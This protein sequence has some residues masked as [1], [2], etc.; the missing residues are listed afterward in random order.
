MSDMLLTPQTPLLL[1]DS[2]YTG[3]LGT[4]TDQINCGGLTAGSARQSDKF[5]FGA[6][7]DGEYVLAV[8]I[9]WASAP[10]AGETVDIYLGY[11]HSGVAGTANPGGLSGADSAYGG[12]SA[13]QADALKQLVYAGSMVATTNATA[14]V[15]ID[16]NVS[17][18]VPRDRYASLVVVNTSASDNFHT[19]GNLAFRLTPIRT[20]T[21]SA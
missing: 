5:D 2:S 8:S 14:T 10:A 16:T 19:A 12:Y 15:Q 18:F 7:F 6:S 21:V 11:S 13:N 3:S 17:T 4:R 1:A 20:S 9:E